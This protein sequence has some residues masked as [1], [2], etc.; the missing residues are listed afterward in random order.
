MCVCVRVCVCVR[1]CVRFRW[2]L[3]LR[4][5]K[6]GG[7]VRFA[8][9]EAAPYEFP[10]EPQHAWLARAYQRIV[11]L[12][13]VRRVHAQLADVLVEDH[14]LKSVDVELAATKAQRHR[15]ALED[16]LHMLQ[17]QTQLTLLDAEV[18]ESIPSWTAGE[19]HC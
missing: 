15:D 5:C 6:Y 16:T 13:A 7:G 4:V 10:L 9:T 17:Q 3:L 19:H 1:R 14:R 8:P 2:D 11:C 18:T 12:C